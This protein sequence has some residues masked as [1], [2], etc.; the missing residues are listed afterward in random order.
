MT[1]LAALEASCCRLAA[2][3]LWNKSHK[4]DLEK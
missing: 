4:T 2:A 3:T 1:H